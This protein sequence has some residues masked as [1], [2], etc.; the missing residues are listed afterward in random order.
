MNEGEELEE[1][2]L[3]KKRALSQEMRPH[4]NH[5]RLGKEFSQRIQEECSPV[6]TGMLTQGDSLQTPSKQN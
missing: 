4:R 2:W 5:K 3:L 6:D 1:T